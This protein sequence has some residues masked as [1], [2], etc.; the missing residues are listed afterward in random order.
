MAQS[1]Y[2][3]PTP[4]PTK[5]TPPTSAPVPQSQ[6]SA[7]SPQAT[8][9]SI[10]KPHNTPPLKPVLQPPLSPEAA[11]LEAQRVGALLDINRALIQEVIMLQEK[12]RTGAAPKPGADQQ[13]QNSPTVAENA[14]TDGK[15][16]AGTEEK[17]GDTK[18]G[19]GDKKKQ[20]P[21]REYMEYVFF[22]SIQPILLLIIYRC[23]R[24]LQ[25]NLAY[26][27][28]LAERPFKR[29]D[30]I[31][32]RPVIME[33][34]PPIQGNAIPEE[35]LQDIKDLYKT[36]RDLYPLHPPGAQSQNQG[37]NMGASSLPQSALGQVQ[38]QAMTQKPAGQVAG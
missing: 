36:L 2:P 25:A 23:M 7:G 20:I 8:T 11:R 14:S 13:G 31:P 15:D 38:A 28:V 6:M 16:A 32:E 27:A 3:Q 24:R 26:L 4:S 21:C 1:Y 34:L 18:D 35:T 22:R 33:A 5:P 37:Q 19:D 10:Q 29:L 12:G 9:S 30:Q 17:D